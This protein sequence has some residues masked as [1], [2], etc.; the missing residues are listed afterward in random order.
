VFS[1]NMGLKLGQSFLGNFLNLLHHYPCTSCREG[2][3]WVEGFVSGWYPALSTGSLVS[4]KE[5][6]TS[7]SIFPTARCFN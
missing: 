2:K 6:A 4:I 7:G 1:H 5:V 3:F